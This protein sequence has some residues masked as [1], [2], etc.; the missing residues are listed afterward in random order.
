MLYCNDLMLGEKLKIFITHLFNFSIY[1]ESLYCID[2][3]FYIL[4]CENNMITLIVVNSI[5]LIEK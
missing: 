4:F 1:F 3:L 2:F 5:Y